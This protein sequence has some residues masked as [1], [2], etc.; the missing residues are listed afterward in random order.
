M[1]NAKGKGERERSV[2]CRR[3]AGRDWNEGLE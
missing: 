2:K 3:G 1:G